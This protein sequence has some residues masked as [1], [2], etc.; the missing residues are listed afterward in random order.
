MT[1]NSRLRRVVGAP[2]SFLGFGVR[3]RRSRDCPSGRRVVDHD[4][5]DPD[6]NGRL[7]GIE[8]IRDGL[9]GGFRSVRRLFAL[10][11]RPEHA[12]C[13]HD[14]GRHGGKDAAVVRRPG[15]GQSADWPGARQRWGSPSPDPGVNK[16][17]LGE[18]KRKDIGGEQV[19][20]AGKLLYLF[21]IAPHQFSGENFVDGPPAPT[22]ARVLVPGVGEGRKPATGA[23]A[24]TTE[25]IPNGPTVL[26]ADMFQGM[27]ATPI[28][29]YTYSKDTKN[30]SA[31]SGPAP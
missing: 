3:G 28:V 2:C 16:H 30:H 23:I 11:L 25:I 4:H 10:R 5:D 6:R 8:P 14:Q 15:D 26:A 12:E 31:C 13:L 21:D 29:V 9:D 24:V 20:Y 22:L 27:G 17:L 1:H 7:G 18:V 19:T